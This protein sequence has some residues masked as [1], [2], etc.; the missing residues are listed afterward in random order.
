MTGQ[1]QVAP[2]K[3]GDPV[4]FSGEAGEDD[5][6]QTVIVRTGEFH[7]FPVYLN[8]LGEFGYADQYERL[9]TMKRYQHSEVVMLQ[10]KLA[11]AFVMFV[12]IA[13]LIKF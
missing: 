11:L 1:E 10:T 7:G 12:I 4:M 6:R 13:L 9:T 5:P 3:R 2:L 8:A